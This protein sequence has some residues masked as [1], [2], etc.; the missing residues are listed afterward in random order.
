M[1][2]HILKNEW[3]LDKINLDLHDKIIETKKKV[4]ITREIKWYIDFDI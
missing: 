1:K 3:Y 4:D 2:T